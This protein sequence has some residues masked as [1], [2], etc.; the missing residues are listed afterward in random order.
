MKESGF[1]KN[2]E[3]EGGKGNR[4]GEYKIF[5]KEKMTHVNELGQTSFIATSLRSDSSV[6]VTR[7]KIGDT[8]D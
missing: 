4:R 7:G 3:K 1:L 8:H 5:L 2:K 6:L